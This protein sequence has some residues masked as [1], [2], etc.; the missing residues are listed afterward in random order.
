MKHEKIEEILRKILDKMMIRERVVLIPYSCSDM[1]TEDVQFA[2]FVR[3]ANIGGGIYKVFYDPD[4][5]GK[6]VSAVNFIIHECCHIQ[7]SIENMLIY[8]MSSVYWKGEKVDPKSDYF[9]RPHEVDCRERARKF[10]RNNKEF[11]RSLKPQTCF[12]KFFRMLF[13]KK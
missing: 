7:Q 6:S 5:V 4:I 9:T 13:S 12:G 1:S 2:G 11:V 8:D 3:F 10:R